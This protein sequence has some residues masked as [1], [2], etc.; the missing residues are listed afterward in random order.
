[1]YNKFLATSREPGAAPAQPSEKSA[2]NVRERKE[3]KAN[4]H[5]RTASGTHTPEKCNNILRKRW[6]S[7]ARRLPDLEY[8]S[9]NFAA[10]SSTFF[11]DGFFFVGCLAFFGDLP[12]LRRL[13]RWQHAAGKGGQR[14]GACVCKRLDG[15]PVPSPAH[16]SHARFWAIRTSRFIRARARWHTMMAVV[17]E[18]RRK[19]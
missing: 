8:I 9:F 17:R 12:F 14:R 7:R 15:G 4:T 1:M 3:E 2:G 19:K 11:F 5:A 13:L 18:K 16:H 6:R 10:P